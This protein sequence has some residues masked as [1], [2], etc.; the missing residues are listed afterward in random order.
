MVREG[1]GFTK[2]WLDLNPDIVLK[3]AEGKLKNIPEPL[4]EIFPAS[5]LSNV[6]D[7]DVLCLAAGGGQQSA[8]FGLLGARV[9]V[10][11]IADGQLEGDKKAAAHYGYGVKTVQGDIGD[12]SALKDTFFDLV[13]QAPSMCYVG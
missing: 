10:I 7:K 3:F 8:V 6:K 2:P 13:Y 5:A 9:T 12:L 1:C 11:D 4:N